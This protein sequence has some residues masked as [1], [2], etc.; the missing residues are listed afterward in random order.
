MGQVTGEKSRPGGIL[1]SAGRSI[2]TGRASGKCLHSCRAQMQGWDSRGKTTFYRDGEGGWGEGNGSPL[3]CSCLENPR[4]RGAWRAAVCGVAQSRT[5]LEQRSSSSSK[6]EWKVR[7]TRHSPEGG[8][9]PACCQTRIF[10][11]LQRDTG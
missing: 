6:G 2:K 3:Q 7:D 11:S 1:G 9:C 5:R 8:M 4:D 10:G